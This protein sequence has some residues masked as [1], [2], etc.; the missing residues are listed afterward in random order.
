MFELF[1]RGVTVLAVCNDVIANCYMDYVVGYGAKKKA[2]A[3][4]PF[5]GAFLGRV[6]GPDF[7]AVGLGFDIGRAENVHNFFGGIALF[8]E[9]D[10]RIN[11]AYRRTAPEDQY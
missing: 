1:F 6:I 9:A 5:E 7:T 8:D 2:Q 3:R 4:C 10:I 11:M